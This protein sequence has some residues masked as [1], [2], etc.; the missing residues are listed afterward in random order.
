MQIFP[1][2][3]RSPRLSPQIAGITDNAS[4]EWVITSWDWKKYL[5]CRTGLPGLQRLQP[6][7]AEMARVAGSAE[8]FQS[9]IAESHDQGCWHCDGDC[10]LILQRLQRLL[11]LPR[12]QLLARLPRSLRLSPEIDGITDFA[13]TAE[14]AAKKCRDWRGC[15]ECRIF[16][17][18]CSKP[19]PRLLRLRR[20]LTADIAET[21]EIILS[22]NN[23]DISK[24]VE[25][26]ETFAQDC[27]DNR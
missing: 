16:S 18:R 25:I 20:R 12:M 9:E 11:G 23:A 8:F 15:W 7:N 13:W 6:K 21:A 19:W 3:S 2:L 26:A 4:R 27:R 5:S 24:I 22:A 17:P 1:R 10:R 14:T